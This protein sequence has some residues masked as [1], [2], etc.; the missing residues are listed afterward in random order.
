MDIKYQI[1]ISSTYTDLKEAR[2][3]ITKAILSSYHIPIGMEMFNAGDEEQWEVIKKTIDVSDYYVLII[4]HRY[5][6]LT[7]EGISYTEKEYRYAKE[8]GIPIHVF[9]RKDDVAT[10]PD[11]R[12]ENTDSIL[13]LKAFREEAKTG[14]IVDFW[15]H[16]SELE[17]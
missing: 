13:K 10:K 15:E 3:R 1:F 17:N 5:G 11:E 7:D 12:E 14:R 8:K 6:S 16:I 4:G 9:I 2:E